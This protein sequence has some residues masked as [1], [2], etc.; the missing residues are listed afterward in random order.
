MNKKNLRYLPTIL[1]TLLPALLWIYTI[2]V[3]IISLLISYHTPQNNRPSIGIR[4]F[5]STSSENISSL[6]W[7]EILLI[8]MSA[9]MIHTSRLLSTT[10]RALRRDIRSNRMRS[11]LIATAVTLMLIIAL[12]IPTTIYPWNLT[13]SITGEFS[14]SPIANGWA[15]LLTTIIAATT[16]V[17][18]IIAGTYRNIEDI[19]KGTSHLIATHAHSIAALIPAAL[20]INMS[21]HMNYPLFAHPVAEYIFLLLPFLCD[22]Y[23]NNK[24]TNE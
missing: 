20:F 2:A 22:I 6:P 17:F 1:Y 13:T 5:L 10:I 3:N 18:G 24:T 19:I 23:T 15:I 9:S 21:N 16:T 4:W 14:E 8:L 12:L 11:A 7:G